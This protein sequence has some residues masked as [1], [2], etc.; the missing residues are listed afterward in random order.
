MFRNEKSN[1]LFPRL[2]FLKETKFSSWGGDEHRSTRVYILDWSSLDEKAVKQGV[3]LFPRD[4][5]DWLN[6][7]R[8]ALPYHYRSE[9][10]RCVKMATLEW[11]RPL[12]F[13]TSIREMCL[14]TATKYIDVAFRLLADCPYDPEKDYFYRG[15]DRGVL[16]FALIYRFW[17]GQTGR[18][19]PWFKSGLAKYCDKWHRHKIETVHKPYYHEPLDAFMVAVQHSE[20]E[21]AVVHEA[22]EDA[23]EEAVAETSIAASCKHLKRVAKTTPVL[24]QALGAANVYEWITDPKFLGRKDVFPQNIKLLSTAF[25]EYCPNCGYR[26][27]KHKECPV[28]KKDVTEA[29]ARPYHEV[30]GVRGQRSGN[31]FLSAV[32]ATY[33]L[34]KIFRLP[35]PLN[36][37][38]GM[39]PNVEIEMTFVD[40]LKAIWET[41]W[42][43]VHESQWFASG[44]LL[45]K[46]PSNLKEVFLPGCTLVLRRTD[47]NE[48]HRGGTRV[49]ATIDSPDWIERITSWGYSVQD[50]YQALRNSLVTLRGR[51][52][53]SGTAP[54]L[55]LL[56]SPSPNS[57]L[58][59]LKKSSL[60]NDDRLW[61]Q[62]P[63]WE[64]NPFVTMEQ[65][66][67]E[68]MGNPALFFRDYGAQIPEPSEDG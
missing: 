35:R 41:F 68:D 49:F 52:N 30:V 44:S 31:T 1:L 48:C 34:H 13:D 55:F 27:T 39:P 66:R 63:T 20:K 53:K 5:I 43:L 18:G 6:N 24:P 36:E 67:K 59:S 4:H 38:F 45:A 14:G 28:C 51:Q 10:R 33:V 54:L 50:V 65:L 37:Q 60:D 19:L 61:V 57:F 42:R 46:D 8:F 12:G 62:Q 56:G 58:G 11:E 17:D 3:R 22:R 32:A 9:I 40:P 64:V 21:Y 26:P 16:P 25:Q 29:F 23:S 7:F 2:V 15:D 47:L